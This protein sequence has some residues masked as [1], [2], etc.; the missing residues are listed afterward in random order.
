MTLAVFSQFAARAGIG[1]LFFAAWDLVP[2]SLA[3]EGL[4]NMWTNFFVAAAGA[5]A[6]LAG[7]VFVAISVN[8]GRILQVPHL[9]TRAGATIGSLVL[10]LV[11]SMDALIPQA[12]WAMGIQ[13]FIVSVAALW[14]QGLS[15]WRGLSLRKQMNRPLWEPTLNAIL[16]PIQI[17]PFVIGAMLL[18]AQGDSGIYWI[19]RGCV[20]VFVLSTFNAWVLLVEILR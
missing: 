1:L 12:H 8:I 16:G 9:P 17:L 11:S 10:I 6:A 19:A 20:L 18:A 5:S 3:R 2:G 7:L 14:L 13:I 15:A 4:E